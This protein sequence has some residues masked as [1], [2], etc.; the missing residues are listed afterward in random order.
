MHYIREMST[1]YIAAQQKNGYISSS[2]DAQYKIYSLGANDYYDDGTGNGY[3]K[4]NVEKYSHNFL[5]GNSEREINDKIKEAD[6][7]RKYGSGK[8][9]DL[10]CPK[11]G[12]WHSFDL[13]NNEYGMMDESFSEVRACLCG[14][15]FIAKVKVIVEWK[16]GKIS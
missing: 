11:C 16:I 9:G 15:K 7:S 1:K 5:F 14:E 6:Y 2:P 3:T 12:R 13:Y 4:Q 10:Q 8:S